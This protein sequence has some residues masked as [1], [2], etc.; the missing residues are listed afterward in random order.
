MCE[1]RVGLLALGTPMCMRHAHGD[2]LSSC[3]RHHDRP[4]RARRWVRDAARHRCAHRAGGHGPHA[5]LVRARAGCCR[6]RRRGPARAALGGG[7]QRVRHVRRR[8]GAAALRHPHDA[9]VAVDA[10]DGA[11]DD[12]AVELT[13]S[14]MW[15]AAVQH[16]PDVFEEVAIRMIGQ[17]DERDVDGDGTDDPGRR[18]PLHHLLR[19]R[20]A[21][22][23][24]RRCPS[25]TRP[26][27]RATGSRSWGSG[28]ARSTGRGCA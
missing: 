11:I 22:S 20:R 18:A 9:I 14:Q 15:F 7:G 10:S 19:R 24:R 5:T 27:S 13:S 16:I 17:Y 8:A 6:L 4:A 2:S 25:W 3:A 28:T 1:E 26:S 21:A 12:H 23:S